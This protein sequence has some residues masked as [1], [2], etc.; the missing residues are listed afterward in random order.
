LSFGVVVQVILK[1]PNSWA[2]VASA[3]KS[4]EQEFPPSE[5]VAV[6]VPEIVPDV[7]VRGLP[8]VGGVA[9]HLLTVPETVATSV[10]GLFGCSSK[11]GEKESLPLRALQE[12]E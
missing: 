11:G 1:F 8:P 3:G 4:N 10:T 5:G 9:L 6:R 7:T 12:T 2:C